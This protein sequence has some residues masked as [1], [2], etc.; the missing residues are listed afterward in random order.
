[1]S[2]KIIIIVPLLITL[3]FVWL[4]IINPSV[5]DEYVEAL[6]VDYR[7]KIRNLISPPPIPADVQLVLIDEPSIKE[8]GGWQWDRKLQAELVEKV[9]RYGPKAVALD[10][11]YSDPKDPEYDRAL[12]DVFSRYKDR[13]VV[14]L[15]FGV[16]EGKKFEGEIEDVLYDN[17]IRKIENQSFL[18]AYEAYKVFLPEEGPLTGPATYGHVVSPPDRDGKLRKESLYIKYGDEYFPSLALQAA[19]I[20]KGLPLD[21]IKIIGGAGV[22]LDGLFIPTDKFGRVDVNYI[23][24]QGSITSIHA[25]DVLSGRLPEGAFRDKVVFIGTSAIATFDTK[26]TPFSAIMP[27]VEKNATVVSNIIKRNFITPAPDYV[28]VLVVIVVGIL[29]LLMS[30]KQSAVRS[31]NWYVILTL[32]VMA[33]NQFLF[34][35]HGVRV[36]YIYPI[37]TLMTE[38]T[39]IISYR[40]FIEEKSARHVR[41]IFSSYVTERVVNELMKNPDMARLGGER[42]DITVLFS[43]IRGFTTFSE[44]H[45]PEEVVHMLNEYLAE[46]TD[47]IFRWE[48]TLDKF[49]G[50]EILAFWGAPMRQDNHAELA[51]RCALNMSQELDDLQ[52]KWQ[53]EGKPVLNAGIGINSGEVIVGNI[54]AEGKKM[55]YTVI[56]DHVNLGARVEGLTKKYNTRILITEFTKNR[57]KDLVTSGAISHLSVKGLERVIVKGKEQPISIYEVKSLDHGSESTI[58][59]PEKD[60]IVRHREK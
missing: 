38:G 19:R 23:G 37:Y 30:I 45:S 60:K 49:V 4:T 48:G 43:D 22:E 50:D 47:V 14:A 31:F 55:D 57:I 46:M 25:S 36:N 51:L 42:R 44:K 6:F 32:S 7:F 16:K 8:Y 39:F 2:G 18:N 29:G 28:N 54:G 52:R 20:Y 59:E 58:T 56:G 24:K 34:S 3:A 27:G 12:A 17:A 11:F 21:S 40:Y 53:A 1:M 15:T 35:F 9:F 13:L 26:I 41:K 5:I 33:A 10:I